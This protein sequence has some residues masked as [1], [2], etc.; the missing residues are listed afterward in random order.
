MIDETNEQICYYRIHGQ[1]AFSADFVA[2]FL[3]RQRRF[4]ELEKSLEKNIDENTALRK[5]QALMNQ[6]YEKVS[7]LL[8][9]YY[10]DF[11]IYR[12]CFSLRM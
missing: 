1:P 4:T 7:D 8:S 10:L 11:H 5:Q 12:F 9:E 3:D 2:Y 6:L